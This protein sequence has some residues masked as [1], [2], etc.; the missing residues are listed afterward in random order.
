[1]KWY[2]MNI[3]RISYLLFSITSL[4][5][6][7][8]PAPSEDKEIA[9][10]RRILISSAAMFAPGRPCPEFDPTI[11]LSS[12][13][14]SP[15]TAKSPDLVPKQ[16]GDSDTDSS[17]NE[18]IYLYIAKGEVK[19]YLGNT[20]PSLNVIKISDLYK[21]LEKNSNY[22]EATKSSY[23][24][25][26]ALMMAM[27]KNRRKNHNAKIFSYE[28]E[29]ERTDREGKTALHYAAQNK[30][31]C[32]LDAIKTL[33][34]RGANPL[35]TCDPIG[36]GTYGDRL[37]HNHAPQPRRTP[38]MIAEQELRSYQSSFCGEKDG[39]KRIPLF[40]AKIALLKEAEQTSK[41]QEKKNGN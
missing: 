40:Q 21:E 10:F 19:D 35:A 6:A 24:N 38:L 39:Q 27:G 9:E 3:Y 20:Y 41:A 15:D 32:S 29:L 11:D 34:E 13:S 5:H 26:T 8:A 28:P 33:I 31:R 18:D 25:E 22:I 4:I 12:L 17:D 30:H 36:I 37:V 23:L 7:S 14:E 16:N 1:M 2:A